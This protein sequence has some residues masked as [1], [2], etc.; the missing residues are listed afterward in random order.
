LPLRRVEVQAAAQVAAKRYLLF[1]VQLFYLR[2]ADAQPREDVVR[3]DSA[4]ILLRCTS[5]LAN[6][7][8]LDGVE[9]GCGNQH[10]RPIDESTQWLQQAV[11]DST[12]QLRRFLA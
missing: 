8:N 1:A 2:V 11:V 9:C 12:K 5:N 10:L 6:W 4:P 7:K 3:R